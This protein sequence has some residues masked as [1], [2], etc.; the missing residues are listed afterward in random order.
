[1]PAGRRAGLGVTC[2]ILGDLDLYFPQE[3]HDWHDGR[4][5]V[6]GHEG[7]DASRREGGGRRKAQRPRA[8]VGRALPGAAAAAILV[9]AAA[10]AAAEFT[11]LADSSLDQAY[12]REGVDFSAYDALLL[13]A[14][15]VWYPEAAAPA[16]E[17]QPQAQANLARAQG[18]FR[19]A[20]AAAV[21][22]AYEIV[23]QAGPH[24]LRVHAEFVDLRALA[25]G[26]PVPEALRDYSFRVQAGHLTLVASLHDAASGRELARAADLSPRESHGDV[27]N[28][29]WTRIER[30][31]RR[32]AAIFADWLL[33]VRGGD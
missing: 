22:D 31:L 30:D 23:E 15:S 16:R 25:P 29:D 18:L 14:I 24:V 19:E 2:E 21:G 27:L 3:V 9:L 17:N 26:E 8:A 28:V 33:E 11:R 1:M 10:G 32:W 5:P 7:S 6:I 4:A 20:I 13:D 12:V